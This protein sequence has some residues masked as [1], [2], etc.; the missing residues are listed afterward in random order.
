MITTPEQTPCFWHDNDPRG[1][2]H[3]TMSTRPS[4]TPGGTETTEYTARC[5]EYFPGYSNDGSANHFRNGTLKEAQEK[6]LQLCLDCQNKTVLEE[7][8]GLDL[9]KRPNTEST[10]A[11][12]RIKDALELLKNLSEYYKGKFPGGDLRGV[13]LQEPCTSCGEKQVYCGYADLGANDYYDNYFHV[14]LNCYDAKHEEKS[15]NWLN[16]SGTIPICPF[17]KRHA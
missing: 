12:A 4:E 7:I 9:S 6:R 8:L 11:L 2:F 5:G 1:I 17:C 16:G 3:R 10:Q 14:C 13:I 15:E